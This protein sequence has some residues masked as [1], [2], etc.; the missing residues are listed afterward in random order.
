MVSETQHV[1]YIL[2]LLVVIR[3]SQYRDY[4]DKII[5]N[6]QNITTYKIEDYASDPEYFEAYE[7][8]SS[9]FYT[10]LSCNRLVFLWYKTQAKY[11]IQPILKIRRKSFWLIFLLMGGVESNPGP[12]IKYPYGTYN[13]EVEDFGTRTLACN[14]CD[15][16]SHK[17]CVGMDTSL[18]EHLANSS[19]PWFCTKCGTI[20]QSS[21]LFDIPAIG[22]D[23]VG[24]S[25]SS[26][27][28]IEGYQST[29]RIVK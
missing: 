26:M 15:Q 23:S 28:S 18:F 16:W 17:S 22:I 3:H 12:S 19:D 14:T 24:S 6:Y 13:K 20:N 29:Q 2:L 27:G 5:P 10:S 4:F 7:F 25:Y 8:T 1:Y 21:I 9:N 11:Y